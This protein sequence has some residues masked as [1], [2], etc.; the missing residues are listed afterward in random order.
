MTG[1]GGDEL[2]AG[3]QGYTNNHYLRY[4]EWTFS[5]LTM[6]FRSLLALASLM[7]TG[8]KTILRFLGGLGRRVGNEGVR[9]SEQ[10]A[11]NGIN[12]LNLAF[13]KN[14][15]IE[16]LSGWG[17]NLVA[18]YYNFLPT[19]DRLFRM[20]YSSYRTRLADEMLM[21]VDRMTMAHSLEARVPLLDNRLVEFAFALP[22]EMKLHS[23]GPKKTGKYIFKKAME[24]YLNNEIV[25]R[26]KKGFDIPVDRWMNG[27]FLKI[28]SD[29]I[30]NGYLA[31]N[32]IID[33]KGVTTLLRENEIRDNHYQNVLMLLY[34]FETWAEVFQ[35]EFG[36]VTFT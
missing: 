8:N 1:D 28:V 15:F 11:Q 27:P 13:K 36:P 33:R 20:L 17:N 34:T 3:Y 2:F 9:F 6:A 22:P 19:E 16:A 10:I 31:K 24:R 21:K 30:T 26:T 4:P 35:G 29:R 25:Y 5:L 32:G 23:D 7:P 18:Y 12:T 14:F